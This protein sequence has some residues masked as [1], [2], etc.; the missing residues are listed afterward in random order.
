[1]QAK[2]LVRN[3]DFKRMYARG[4]SVAGRYVVLYHMRNRLGYNRLGLT[5]GKKVGNAVQRN[6]AKRLMRESFRLLEAHMRT[7]YD[8][9]LVARSN[10][11]EQHGKT[12]LNS[13][14]GQLQKAGLLEQAERKAS[15]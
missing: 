1:M 5:A 6:R 10:L 7:G 12:V 13:L 2:S 9:V 15:S 3:G 11:P 4:K 8:I 14:S